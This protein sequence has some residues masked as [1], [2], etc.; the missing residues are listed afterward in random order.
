MTFPDLTRLV[1]PRSIAIIGAS[2]REGSQGKRLYDNVV[3]HS[4]FGGAVFP[5]N[6]AYKDIA[7]APC[8]PS[9]EAIPAGNVDLALVIVNASAVLETLRQCAA[10]GIPFAVVMTSGFAE[11]GG[12]GSE[13]EAQIATL[14]RSTGLHVYGPNCPG[15]VN[16][17]D[18]LGCTF[19]PAF[20]DDLNAGSIGLATQGGGL[21]RNVLQALTHGEGVGLWFSGG[22]EVDL[23]LPDFIA[24]M[25]KDSAIRVIAVLMEGVKNGRRLIEAFKLAQQAG[26]PVVV[27]K[28]GRSDYGVKAAQSHTASI[29]GSAKVNSAVF[30]QYG[31]IE[32]D[33][34]HELAAVSRLAAAGRRDASSGLCIFTFSGG[35]A[36]LAAD[37]V[38]TAGLELVELRPE[39]VAALKALLPAFANV[40]NPVDTTADILRDEKLTGEC[41]RIVCADKGVSVVLFPIPM[42][43]GPITKTMAQAIDEVARNTDTVIVPVWMSRRLGEGFLTLDMA[44]RMP[45]FSLT[46]AVGAL[47]KILPQRGQVSSAPQVHA[48]QAST[49]QASALSEI[50]AK[51]RLEQA[52]ITVPGGRLARSEDE[53]CAHASL[54]SYP[55]VLKVVSSQITH[56][57]EAGGVKLG[58]ATDEQLRDAYRAIHRNVASHRPDAVVEGLLVE[59]MFPAGGR[60][61]LVGVHRDPAFGLIL[62]FGLGGIFVE[63]LKDVTH[64]ALPITREDARAMVREIRAYPLLAGVRG[65]APADLEA[66]EALLLKV[67]DFAC[68]AGDSLQE[69]DLNP[70]WVGNAG[71]GAF[72]LDALLVTA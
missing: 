53:A 18:R 3:L 2:G 48:A 27:L 58:I 60:E 11:V 10:R 29:A 66:L 30:K 4:Q 67:S 51:A 65:Q 21:G 15:F 50:D 23:G 16:I 36:A 52:G 28:V 32:V 61:V 25:A 8:W 12:E 20:K 63:V 46:D 62:T 31:V 34:L 49:A 64:R 13:L 55:V 54:L 17:R 41:L 9:V 71:Q 22:N 24:H 35:T 40:S 42:D 44:G 7:G 47:K 68:A 14:C 37:I 38:G 69:L 5:V 6:P 57:T 72:P 70:V 33:D 1:A 59:K 43:Y 39:S 45:F 26:K 19:S 56:K